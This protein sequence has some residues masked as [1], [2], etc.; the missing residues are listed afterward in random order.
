MAWQ[1]IFYVQRVKKGTVSKTDSLCIGNE[2]FRRLRAP[3]ILYI[4][5]IVFWHVVLINIFEIFLCSSRT[6]T[7]YF[8]T[9][10]FS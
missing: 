7:G 6:T 1:L 2:Q 4:T 9:G 3:K 10:W 5:I 8:Y